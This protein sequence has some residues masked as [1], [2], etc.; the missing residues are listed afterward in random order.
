MYT[1]SFWN[2]VAVNQLE[3]K[4]KKLFLP[5]LGLNRRGIVLRNVSSAQNAAEH[6]GGSSRSYSRCQME[7]EVCLGAGEQKGRWRWGKMKG[8]T[9]V[10]SFTWC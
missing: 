3:K 10:T 6:R 4:K 7:G 1:G 9:R 8:R 2:N 5:K